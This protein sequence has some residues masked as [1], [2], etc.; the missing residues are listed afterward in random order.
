LGGFLMATS[1]NQNDQFSDCSIAEMQPIINN[2]NC[3]VPLPGTD[4][5]I[6]PATPPL[7]AL[8]GNSAT[9]N[10]AVRNNG[11]DD[12]QNVIVDVT[13]PSLADIVSVSSTVGTCT[14]GAGTA[15]CQLGTVSGTGT[16]TVVI[17]TLTS[18]V[19]VDSFLASVSATVDDANSN[20]QASV[21]LTVDPA[22][23]LVLT[24]PNTVQLAL[25]QSTSVAVSIDNNSVLDAN[26]VV[27]DIT[28][29]VGVSIES[30]NWSGAACT[31]T[32]QQVDCQAS[33]I[34]SQSGTSVTLGVTGVS[35]G[36]Q[37]YSIT[38]SSDE[39]D[40]NPANNSITGSVSV[41]SPQSQEED[42][43]GGA[44]GLVTLLFLM[45]ATV[46]RRSRRTRR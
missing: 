19:G 22:V 23:D 38:V 29:D 39:D 46:A 37:N 31:V 5:S 21:S 9:T 45:L 36:V 10:F 17:S 44:T 24:V 1:V 43:G 18:S 14:S 20:N 41:N 8:L 33:V 4:I 30:A 16:A 12:A 32:G 7:V 3:F 28:V 42:S 26:N 2:A 15:S 11:A 35:A 13:I 6:A 40:R 25:D 34:G 27:V